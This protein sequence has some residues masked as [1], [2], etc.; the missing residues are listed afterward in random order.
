MKNITRNQSGF[1][2]IELIVVIA[3]LGV[4]AAI[5][6]PTVSNYLNSS[7]ERAWNAEQE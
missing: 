7:K 2:L 4:L 3:I 1:T 6:V 5:A